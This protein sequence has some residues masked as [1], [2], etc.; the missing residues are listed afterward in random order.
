MMNEKD[1]T[2]IKTETI[3]SIS[4][5]NKDLASM[6]KII[7]KYGSAV[8]MKNN[9]PVY[10]AIEASA[11]DKEYLDKISSISI[12]D[13]SINFSTLTYKVYDNGRVLITKRNVPVCVF[14]SY[15]YISKAM[16]QICS[17]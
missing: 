4:Q 10:M 15:S 14:Y 3:I 17:I 6:L 13:A 12:R 7:E 9:V 2:T 16:V 5:V 11:F 1:I 8:V